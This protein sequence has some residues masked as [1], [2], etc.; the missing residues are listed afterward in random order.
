MWKLSSFPL[1][2]HL[3][4]LNA[5]IKKI[6]VSSCHRGAWYMDKYTSRYMLIL[7]YEYANILILFWY[8]K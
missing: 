2:E 5:D 6:K 7:I 3:Q 8:I 4:W 1:L